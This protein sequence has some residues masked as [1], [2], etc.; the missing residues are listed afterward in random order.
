MEFKNRQGQNLGRI[1]LV[2]TNEANVYDVIFE[3]NASKQGTPLTEETFKAFKEEVL[4]EI[5]NV[6]LS[7]GLRGPQGE[8]GDKCDRSEQGEKGEPEAPG[9]AATGFYTSSEPFSTGVGRYDVSSVTYNKPELVPGDLILST[10]SGT[11]VRVRSLTS[12]GIVFVG[13]YVFSFK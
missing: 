7:Q 1:K 6:T 9:G 3:D 5:A 4:N 2:A 13:E 8:K 11:L 12:D 10:K